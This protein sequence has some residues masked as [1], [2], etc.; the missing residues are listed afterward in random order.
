M[1]VFRVF[2]F[3][4]S[5]SIIEIKS[6]QSDLRSLTGGQEVVGST[7]IYS[8]RKKPNILTVNVL[9]FLNLYDY[10]TVSIIK[11][12]KSSLKVS[13]LTP[14]TQFKNIFLSELCC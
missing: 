3:S 8:T 11:P 14:P 5:P 13:I 2:L 9:F 6:N 1:P 10:C 7:P 4:L 12:K